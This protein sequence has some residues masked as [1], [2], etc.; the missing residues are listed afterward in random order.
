MSTHRTTNSAD[1][2][3][4]LVPGTP[5]T[6]GDL[7]EKTTVVLSEGEQ[8]TY[9]PY[10]PFLLD[11][12]CSPTGRMYAGIR[13]TLA[14]EVLPTDL[15]RLVAAVQERALLTSAKKDEVREANGRVVRGSKGECAVGNAVS[16]FRKVFA[17]GVAD[18]HVA[19]AYNP[20][21]H[22]SK[23][24]RP[25]NQRRP[26]QKCWLEEMWQ[27]VLNGGDDPELDAMMC[28]FFLITGARREGL[29]NL[30]VRDV[31]P[32][33]GMVLLDEKNN[34]RDEQPVPDWFALQLLAFAASRGST[35]QGDPV[36]RYRPGQ[37]IGGVELGRVGRS[38]F[39]TLFGRLQAG[40]EWADRVGLC[41]HVLRHHAY[42]LIERE[43]GG[44]RVA[45][46]FARHRPDR[47]SLL[48]GQASTAEV[49]LAI[50]ELHGGTHPLVDD[51]C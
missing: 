37:S 19:W 5:I 20:A 26:L 11:G 23:P 4:H 29:I 12:W 35:A 14:H 36:F 15:E 48:Y 32:S 45:E 51:D 22:L 40:A 50:V 46:K 47:L 7:V 9:G 27:L 17:V 44:T 49:A 2:P 41:A 18:R 8:R 1:A 43:A 38:R 16:A 13:D 31:V 25:A 21:V 6:M 33:T 3:P 34:Q 28:Q 10:L 39:D 30:N 24:T 42:A